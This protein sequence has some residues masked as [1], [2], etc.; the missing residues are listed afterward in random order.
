LDD[1]ATSPSAQCR[2]L[3]NYGGRF[4]KP[5][6][7]KGRSGSAKLKKDKKRA[8]DFVSGAFL[9]GAA[10]HLNKIHPQRRTSEQNGVATA[11]TRLQ[12]KAV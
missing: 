11:A 6:L 10:S 12:Q 2:R 9:F 8:R 1:E 3:W 5:A 4:S 7:K